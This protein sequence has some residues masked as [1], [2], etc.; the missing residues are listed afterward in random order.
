M[1][2]MLAGIAEARAKG[3]T[4]AAEAGSEDGVSAA[5][6]LLQHYADKSTKH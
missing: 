2:L 5:H 1:E 4:D 3:A 6:L